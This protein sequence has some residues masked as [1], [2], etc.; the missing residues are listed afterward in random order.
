[1]Q[2]WLRVAAIWAIEY[3][4]P[5]SLK[6]MI[7]PIATQ[8]GGAATMLHWKDFRIAPVTIT[9]ANTAEAARKVHAEVGTVVQGLRAMSLWA[10]HFHV[11]DAYN[12]YGLSRL[13]YVAPVLPRGRSVFGLDCA[14]ALA[15]SVECLDIYNVA[16]MTNRSLPVAN[17]LTV[18]CDH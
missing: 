13:R 15:G 11:R 10:P 7:T 14:L 4:V 6:T 12:L 16:R 17:T 5:I 1:M 8:D 3:G 18:S 2:S 9:A